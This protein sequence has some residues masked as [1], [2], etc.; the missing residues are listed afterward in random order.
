MTSYYRLSFR[1][2]DAASSAIVWED[3]Y[4][5]KKASTVGIMYR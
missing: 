4:E 2:T 3:E 1:L 5:I